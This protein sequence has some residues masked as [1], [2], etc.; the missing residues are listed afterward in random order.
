MTKSDE[1]L[2]ELAE[3][4]TEEPWRLS[5]IADGA[6]IVAIN[7]ASILKQLKRIEAWR[8]FA[9]REKLSMSLQ[10]R[11]LEDDRLAAEFEE[12]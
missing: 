7:P 9:A 10:I 4:A 2:R 5:T 11:L 3:K 1:Q 6:Y 8:S 12:K